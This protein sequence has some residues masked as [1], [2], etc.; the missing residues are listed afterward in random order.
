MTD[1]MLGE[2]EGL[3]ELELRERLVEEANKLRGYPVPHKGRSAQEVPP[4][5]SK[6]KPLT[7][8][9]RMLSLAIKIPPRFYPASL[10][11]RPRKSS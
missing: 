9:S 6:P 1:L 3:S 4:F 10:F 11:S 7:A 8:L 5:S 2:L